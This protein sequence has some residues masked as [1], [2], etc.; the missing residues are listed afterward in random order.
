M[1]QDHMKLYMHSLCKNLINACIKCNYNNNF[2]SILGWDQLFECVINEWL[3][4][5][6]S[7]QLPRI[8]Q[9]VGPMYHVTQLCKECSPSPPPSFLNP[10]SISLSLSLS[11]FLSVSFSLSLCLSFSYPFSLLFPLP[12]FSPLLCLSLPSSPLLFS[13]S[14]SWCS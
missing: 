4:D 13:S 14:S 8:L 7:Y 9:G 2:F 11:V 3:Q 12:L 6:G 5:I 10:L 1:L